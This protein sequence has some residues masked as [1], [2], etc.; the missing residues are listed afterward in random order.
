MED[1]EDSTAGPSQHTDLAESRAE[2]SAKC[3]RR[4]MTLRKRKQIIQSAI[5]AKG[6]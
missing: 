1:R 5:E 3:S 2:M 6:Y 4:L